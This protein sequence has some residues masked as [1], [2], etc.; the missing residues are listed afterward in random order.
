MK[1]YVEKGKLVQGAPI[2]VKAVEQFMK[3][4][5]LTHEQVLNM[6]MVPSGNYDPLRTYYMDRVLLTWITTHH[7]VLKCT[8]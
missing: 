5:G 3:D 7:L 6:K 1:K 8:C 4:I 2:H